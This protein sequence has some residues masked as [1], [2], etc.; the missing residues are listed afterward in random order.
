MRV[1][2]AAL[3]GFALVAAACGKN[4]SQGV[5]VVISPRTATVVAGATQQFTATV[6]GTTNHAVTWSVQE[7]ASGGT[8]SNN[9]LYTAPSSSGTFHVIATSA[10]DSSKSAAATV[11]VNAPVAVTVS[12][13]TKSVIAG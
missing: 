8:V 5:T 1:G 13:K 7:G 9:G 2:T 10:A 12:P 6:T 3:V 11:T 4:S